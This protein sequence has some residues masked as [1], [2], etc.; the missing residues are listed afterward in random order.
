VPGPRG[1]TGPQ[2]PKGDTGPQ[3]PVGPEGPPGKASG[4][5]EPP[6]EEPP[7]EPPV[8]EPPVTR[9]THCFGDPSACGFPDVDTTGVPAGTVLVASGSITA[10]TNGQVIN[11]KDV[12]GTINVTADN[13][14]IENSRVT[15]NGTCGTTNT[16]GNAAIRIDEAAT[17][18]TIKN[19]E[20][21]SVAGDTCEHDIRNTSDASIVG[22]NLYLHGCDSNW[23]GQGTLKNSY[24]I[25]K[26]AISTDHIENVYFNDGTFSAI[27]DT[28]LNPV[29]QTAVIF[30]N[31]GGGF[32]GACKNHLTITNNLLAGGGYT[33]Y[34]CGNASGAGSS[35]ISITNNHFARKPEGYYTNSGSFGIEAYDFGSTWTGNVWDDTGTK[36]P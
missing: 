20:T 4:G 13:V 3:G 5:D 30:G 9:T 36:A 28:L 23:Y 10:S 18:T 15:Q 34:P 19:V 35:V 12:T 2:G 14:T 31:V 22:E 33:L 26:I 21:R 29:S 8:E 17:G 16:C 24:G 7:V 6:A 11:A 27:H 1:A 32:G 25:A